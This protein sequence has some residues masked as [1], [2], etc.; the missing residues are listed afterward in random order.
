LARGKFADVPLIIG[1]NSGEDSL[2][3]RPARAEA[4]ARDP[5]AQRAV[6]K[7]EEA[8]GG[9]P[10]CARLFTDRIMGGPARWVAARRP[11]QAVVALLL[12][13]RRLARSA[14]P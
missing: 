8:A 4:A 7:D 6:Y 10:W 1:S 2:M 14:R 12:L 9:T 13:L 5:P 11:R 3:G